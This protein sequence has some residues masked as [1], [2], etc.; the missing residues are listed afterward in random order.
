MSTTAYSTWP[1]EQR[2]HGIM[3]KPT[4]EEHLEVQQARMSLRA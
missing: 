1:V 2:L 3:T 4:I